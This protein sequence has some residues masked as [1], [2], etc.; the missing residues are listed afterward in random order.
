MKIESENFLWGVATS[1]Y[2]SEG[3]YN[4]V[5]EPQTNWASAE[6]RNDVARTGGASGFWTQYAEDFSRCRAMGL[7][8]FRLGI[9]WSRVQPSHQNESGPAPAFDFDALDH[10]A[11]MIAECR[12]QG[13]EPVVTLHHFVHPAWLG[14]DPWLDPSVLEHFDTYVTTAVVAINEALVQK[15]GQPPIHYYITINE[16]NMFVLNTYFG[17]QFPGAAKYG[18]KTV[19]H[20]YNQLLRAHIRAYNLIHDLYVARGWPVP[21]VTLNNFCSDL[22]W[23]DK[24]LPDLLSVRERGV[25]R[26]RVDAYILGKADEFKAAFEAARIPLQKNLSYRL[27]SILKWF[28]NRLWR[29]RFTAETFAPLLD[30]I[31]ESPRA[32]LF[33]YVGMD[34]YDP[35]M[36]HLFRLPV[37]WDHE[38]KNKSLRAWVMNTVTSKWWDWR[39]LPQ[40]L[41]FFCKYYSDDFGHRPLLIAENGMALRRRPDNRHSHRRDRFTRSQFLRLHVREVV[42]MVGEGVPLIGYLHWS[43]FDN[44]EWGSFTPRFGLFSID[45]TRGTERL[46]EDHMGDRPSETY[47]ELVQEARRN[48]SPPPVFSV[49]TAHR[50]EGCDLK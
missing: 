33:D 36:E 17:T 30:A 47:R 6:E 23:M 5:G 27:G 45:Y 37:L 4:G 3:G 16:P 15:H 21:A 48:P 2:Q 31:Y 19:N 49:A 20:C 10:Y 24:L 38:F 34:Y 26:G 46:V 8:A 9:E 25:A 13:M 28:I 32:R 42:K 18:P 44:Y 43:L 12:R 35:F 41:R 1:G 14:G 7:N 11:G 50:P 39:V 22:Y 40:G 29:G